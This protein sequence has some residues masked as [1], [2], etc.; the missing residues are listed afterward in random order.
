MTEIPRHDNPAR[1]AI[2]D[3][4]NLKGMWTCECG[5]LNVSRNQLCWRCSR[6]RDEAFVPEDAR[7]SGND[8]G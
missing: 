7:A 2:C 3:T 1:C 6:R 8:Q 4:Y 5:A